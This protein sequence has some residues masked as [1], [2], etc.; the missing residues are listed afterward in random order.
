MSDANQPAGGG[1]TTP[2]TW[3]IAAG[4][5]G[6][7][8]LIF[9]AGAGVG[10]QWG[11]EQ[12]GPVAAWLSGGLT[13]AA[14]VVALRQAIIAQR[15]A[16]IAQQQADDAQR[17]SMRLLFDRLVDHEI[18]R[19]RECIDAFSD[20]WAAIVSVDFL[21]FTQGL[22]DLDATFDP[23]E[24]R[25]PSGL[26]NSKIFGEELVEGIQD[27]FR[28]WLT[29]TQPP[30]FRARLVL[31]GTPLESAV[32]EINEGLNDVG[33]K[34]VR[35]LAE[36]ILRGRRPDTTQVTAL[37]H[38]VVRLRDVHVK[39]AELDFSLRRQDAEAAVRESQKR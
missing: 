23:L 25:T 15:Q 10:Q 29:A 19:R 38:K 39:K 16:A 36:P 12:W 5:I 37:W 22:D 9:I 20:L 17:E 31:R 34:G 14:V 11:A 32:K 1:D 4:T 6:A 35:M 18:S 13:L 33:Q 24:Q 30:L 26:S 7:S 2:P 27:F 8:A 28:Q 21:S 3:L